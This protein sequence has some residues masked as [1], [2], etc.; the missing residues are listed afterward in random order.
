[1]IAAETQ[2]QDAYR[3]DAELAERIARIFGY[4]GLSVAVVP[5]AGWKTIHNGDDIQLIADPTMLIPKALKDARGEILPA[6][7]EV[8]AQYSL[9]GIAHELG[10]VDDFLHPDSF[11]H[12]E[13]AKPKEH[14]F[15]NVVNDSVINK[16][17]RNIPLLN[18]ITDEIYKDILFPTDDFTD[19]PK[20][21]QLMY[22][23]LLFNVVPERAPTLD[24]AVK[25]ALDKLAHVE[26]NGRAYDIY[27][28]L[29]HPDTSYEER[30]RIAT[31]HILP[32]YEAFLE[33]DLQE[34]QQE[35]DQ[36]PSGENSD[37]NSGADQQDKIPPS[38]SS[39]PSGDEQS[40][41]ADGNQ[42][43]QNEQT[44]PS[45]W[46]DIYDAY[47]DATGC[48][49]DNETRDSSASNSDPND[50]HTDPHQTIKEIADAIRQKQ[51][52]EQQPANRQDQQDDAL[53][54]SAS[55]AAELQLSPEDARAY[56]AVVK[57]H[58]Q[59]I[60]DTAKVFESLTVPSVEYSSPRLRRRPDTSGL[61]LSARHLHRVVTASQIGTDPAVWMPVETIS[62]REGY[63]FN[64][65]DIHLLVDA[66][67][68]MQGDKADNAAVASIIFMEGLA[69]AR[70]RVARHNPRA[71]KP[72]VRLQ[73]ILFGSDTKVVAPIAHETASEDKGIAFTTI[74]AAAGG[75]TMITGALD[76][77]TANAHA[78][79][80]RTQLVSIVT[81]GDFYDRSAAE[82]NV[83][84]APG[85][86][87]VLQYI[88]RSPS[89]SPIT[90]NFS[91][92]SSS[93]ELPRALQ[94]DLTSISAQLRP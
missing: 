15:W 66:S 57:N 63:S 55:F 54:Q 21:V 60:L 43:E 88:I 94:K 25:A 52:Q 61:K 38:L 53:D 69:L 51:N 19:M 58:H 36:Q 45:D 47:T 18:G 7:I 29:S 40:F 93:S 78:N 4:D 48:G 9:Y 62:K 80:K 31:E 20:H 42:Q 1:M 86:H 10:H 34:R 77:T 70:R 87:T 75:G 5:G 35:Q 3:A 12:M 8:P 46:N 39:P 44:E 85:N 27:R 89:T 32:L 2:Q 90:K 37:E 73:I 74:R 49:H 65:L 41:D 11:K 6:D 28:T 22:G 79:P 92:L 83:K 50:D 56:H 13:D 26:L 76:I 68:S 14:F 24:T 64:G 67:G 71:A 81:D 33:E 84:S 91:R 17:L 59:E 82:N 23:W 72:D 16:R 30:R